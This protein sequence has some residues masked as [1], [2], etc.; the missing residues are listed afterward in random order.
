M[1]HYDCVVVAQTREKPAD[2]NFQS[3]FAYEK[4]RSSNYNYTRLDLY[5][6]RIAFTSFILQLCICVY[7]YLNHIISYF[8]DNKTLIGKPRVD[9]K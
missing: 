5:T 2:G 3:I 8:F 7:N 4:N 1:Q 6:N 9:R